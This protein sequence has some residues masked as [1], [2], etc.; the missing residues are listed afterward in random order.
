VTEQ[1]GEP[2]WTRDLVALLDAGA[3]PDVYHGTNSGEATW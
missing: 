3:E 1:R 2:T